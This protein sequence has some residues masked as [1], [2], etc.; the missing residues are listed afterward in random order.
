MKAKKGIISIASF[1]VL[2]NLMSCASK[3]KATNPDFLGDYEP[4]V[5]K[6]IGINTIEANSK[7]LKAREVKVVFFP[8]NNG[9]R[10]DLRY[11]TN[12]IYLDLTSENR[13]VL[14][15]ALEHYISEYKAGTMDQKNDGKRAYFGKTDTYL[16]WGLLYPGYSTKISQRYE[17]YLLDQGRPYFIMANA[18]TYERNSKGKEDSKKARSPAVRLVLSPAQADILLGLIRQENLQAIVDQLATESGAY[19]L[20][21]WF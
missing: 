12:R 3:P 8:R 18:S 14:I 15:P 17:Y 10:F 16:S 2:L 20:E 19:D 1:V 7:D 13:K 11:S 4:K 6:T 21:D 5:L 9:V